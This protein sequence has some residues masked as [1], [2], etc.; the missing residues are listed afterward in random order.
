[1][2]SG[3]GG[4]EAPTPELLAQLAAAGTATVHEAAGRTPP[5][6]PALRPLQHGRVACGLAFT[7]RCGEA[8]NLAIHRAVAE[9]PA[10]SILVVDAMGDA[11]GYW[12]EILTEAAMARRIAALVIDGGVR[13]TDRIRTLGFPVWTRHVA[14]HGVDKRLPGSLGEAITCGGRSIAAGMVVVADDDGVVAIPASSAV[15]VAAAANARLAREELLIKELR[16]GKLTL[17]LLDLRRS[18]GGND[19]G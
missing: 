18:I 14:L 13:D 2:T 16:A 1:M 3:P 19:P 10:D 9:A 7:V 5:F 8:D 11:R 17:D 12:G 4:E 6:D 15:E